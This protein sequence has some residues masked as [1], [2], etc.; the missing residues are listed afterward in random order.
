MVSLPWNQSYHTHY[1][2]I[3]M[4]TLLQQS[5]PFPG[6]SVI[7]S[8]VVSWFAAKPG[9]TLLIYSIR[10]HAGVHSRLMGQ[11]GKGLPSK[12][13]HYME[14]ICISGHVN[15]YTFIRLHT[16]SPFDDRICCNAKDFSC[17]IARV[18]EWIIMW[19]ERW[20]VRLM[21]DIW[22][23]ELFSNEKIYFWHKSIN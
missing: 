8:K 18:P 12:L 19:Y 21:L 4:K 5:F 6:F 7:I 10:F 2:D 16:G 11:N 9:R 17:V 14:A 20:Y 15:M 23:V 22:D 13:P 1:G 3:M